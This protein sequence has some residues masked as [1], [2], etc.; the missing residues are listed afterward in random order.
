[1]ATNNYSLEKHKEWLGYLQ[2]VGLVV[3][4]LALVKAQAYPN[5]NIS[6]FQMK[7]LNFIKE[8]DKGKYIEDL[9][10]VLI[11]TFDWTGKDLISPSDFQ[12][13]YDFYLKEYDEVLSPD[14]IVKDS[15]KQEDGH[16]ATIILIKSYELGTCLDSKI[17]NDK[18]WDASPQI[19][20]ERLLRENNIPLG[21]LFNGFEFRIVYSPIG[22]SSG[23]L[24]F[25]IDFMTEVAG[26]PVF[27]ALEMLVGEERVFSLKKEQRLASILEESRKFQSEVST[28]LSE[29]VLA[30]LYELLR[31]LQSADDYTNAKLL[32]E[33]LKENPN[34]VYDGLITV[35]LRLVFILYAEDRNLLPD[36]ETY[37]KYYSVGG[38]FEKLRED[39][40]QNPDTMDLRYGA[41]AHLIALFNMIYS[42]IKTEKFEVPARHGHLFDPIRFPFLRGTIDNGRSSL[43]MISDGVIYRVLEN[44][45]ILNGER[46]SYRSLDV[47]QIGSVYETIMGFNLEISKGPSIAIKPLKRHGAPATINL[48]EL[49][50]LQ[51]KNKSKW[52]IEKTDQKLTKKVIDEI[53]LAKTCE[54]IVHAFGNKVAKEATPEI[55]PS[56][57]MIFQPSE[58]RRKSGSHYTPRELTEPIV[59]KALK[60]IFEQLSENP[61]AD[62]ILNLKICDPAMGS[63][64]FLVEACRQLAEKVV[65]AWNFHKQM[66]EIPVDEDDLLHARRLVA[67]KCLY[68]VDKN[69]MAVDLGKLSLWLITFAKDHSFTF[70]DHS[71]KHGDTLVGLSIDQ[72]GS[73]N[74]KVNKE[75]SFFNS[76]IE[77]VI[78]DVE[79]LRTEIREASD[80]IPYSKLVEL[81]EQMNQR[82]DI[83]RA[84]GDI[85]LI[86]YFKGKNEKQRQLYISELELKVHNW[87]ASGRDL[88]EIDELKLIRDGAKEDNRFV[89]FHWDIEFPEVFLIKDAGFNCFIGNP[90][91]AGKNNIVK[92]NMPYYL[93]YLKSSFDDSHGNSDLVAFFFRRVFSLLSH[94]G[95]AGLI[96]TNTISQGDTRHTGLRYIIKNGAHIY[97]AIKRLEWPGN[98]VVVV[99]VIHFKKGR[100]STLKL[101]DSR[102]VKLITAYLFHDGISENPKVLA[103][104]KKISF[105][106]VC[107]LGL[108]F[109]FNDQDKKGDS[110]SITE[111]KDIISKDK[112]YKK[113]IKPYLGGEEVSTSPRQEFYKYI[114][115]FNLEPEEES[116]KYPLLYDL[117]CRKVKPMRMKQTDSWARDK[118]WQL[119]RPRPELRKATSDLTKVLVACQT[120][121]YLSLAFVSS[122]MIFDQKLVVFAKEEYSFFGVIQSSIH[123]SWAYF[124]GSTMKDD[125]VYTSS[126]CFETF[127]FAE[128]YLEDVNFEKLSKEYYDFREKLM[129]KKNEGLTQVYNH[130]HDPEENDEQ[131]LTLRTIHQKLDQFILETYGWS[132]IEL[133]YDF[134]LEYE[135]DEGIGNRKKKKP[136]RFKLIPEVHDEVLARLLKLNQERYEEE[137]TLG[138]HKKR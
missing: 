65:V 95:T 119:F 50:S 55:V 1:M 77:E 108:G 42:G 115:D 40:S 80:I 10:E 30:A 66:P 37:N 8:N 15:D 130:F 102:V 45:L 43:P 136:W 39:A 87:L 79:F 132:D 111:M 35:L 17:A 118:W 69:H 75:M 41:W 14:F 131:I 97:N 23:F 76:I 53:K 85:I 116:K 137:V 93:D 67:Q 112:K 54:E 101:L 59:K 29:Q 4:P 46:L 96:S 24:S 113:I 99:S 44:L 21:F 49:L 129:I 124:L 133:K 31:G 20:F 98:A 12:D 92:S 83:L 74:W 109:T 94:E 27:S 9:K 58:M 90:P 48:D 72:I 126:D 52:I 110:N 3:S 61:T 86:Q 100:D 5:K 26:R 60:P 28:K 104:N 81:E 89:P 19:K 70:L 11:D 71:L 106:G 2:Q 123:Q 22:E 34:L 127:P 16:Y 47:E 105:K 88:L 84:I 82:L 6:K 128:N 36:D 103:A 64:A 78:T 51:D 32:K 57:K 117:L 73:F 33:V 138:L 68:G 7:F 56:M 135:V 107:V 91:F 63:G 38:L 121:K 120:S 114:I 13:E 125:P 134:I 122:N 62:D 18:K 25:P